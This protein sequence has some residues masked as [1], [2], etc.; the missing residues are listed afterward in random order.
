M[1]D[2]RFKKFQCKHLISKDDYTVTNSDF[3][4]SYDKNDIHTK[5]F[6][7]ENSMAIVEEIKNYYQKLYTPDVNSVDNVPSLNIYLSEKF[8]ISILEISKL[9]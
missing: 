7:E 3:Y 2:I 1:Q 4:I 9:Y 5:N 8:N 6:L